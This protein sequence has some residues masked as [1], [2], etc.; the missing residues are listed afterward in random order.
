MDAALVSRHQD[1]A[2]GREGSSPRQ[3]NSGYGTAHHNETIIYRMSQQTGAEPNHAS[4]VRT[5]NRQTRKFTRSEIKVYV[6][7]I[8]EALARALKEAGIN[9]DPAEILLGESTVGNEVTYR[10]KGSIEWIHSR[11]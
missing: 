1:S 7:R 11:S 9:L 8:R 2:V 10:L 6:Q 5:S 3:A 4:N